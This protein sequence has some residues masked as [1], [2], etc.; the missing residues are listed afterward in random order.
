MFRCAIAAL[1]LATALSLDYE[2]EWSEFKKVYRKSY[3]PKE[4][5]I[6][7]AIWEAN[8]NLIQQHNLEADRGVHSYWLGINQLGDMERCGSCWAFSATGSL[9]GQ[10]FKKTGKLVSLSEQNLVDCSQKEG[11]HGCGGGLMD[12]AFRYIEINNGIDTEESYPYIGKSGLCRFLPQDV[13]ATDVGYVDIKRFNEKALQKAVATV[14]PISIGI[15]ASRPTFHLYKTGVY[16]DPKCNSTR[17]DHGVLAVGY[18]EENGEKY[19]LVKNR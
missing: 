5:P 11:N 16:Y 17:L 19:W 8:L 12:Y 7:R 14:G 18:G 6:R 13:G 4:E 1:L 10:H 2:A 9:E 15:D 3:A